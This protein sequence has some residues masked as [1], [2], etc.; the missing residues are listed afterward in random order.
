MISTVNN[1]FARP[2]CMAKSRNLNFQGKKQA[3]KAADKQLKYS[4]E[5]LSVKA[6]FLNS[7]TGITKFLFHRQFIFDTET[8][9]LSKILSGKKINHELLVTKIKNYS[10]QTGKLLSIDEYKGRKLCRT[11]SYYPDGKTIKW[12]SEYSPEKDIIHE[13]Y[14][15]GRSLKA[16]QSDYGNK[17][18]RMEYEEYSG[19]LTRI[20]YRENDELVQ[21]RKYEKNSETNETYKN[22]IISESETIS[23]TGN[24]VKSNIYYDEKGKPVNGK[25]I[26]RDK[27]Y[28]DIVWEGNNVIRTK[29][30]KNGEIYFVKTKNLKTGEETTKYHNKPNKN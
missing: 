30:N 21:I 11:I 24:I 1:N 22:G 7:L 15:D 25:H 10:S 26:Y 23:E 16:I 13:F 4:T 5:K 18:S 29:Y 8:G 3:L 2:I 14:P 17:T 19:R 12:S 27:T 20:E 28:A 9:K 6:L